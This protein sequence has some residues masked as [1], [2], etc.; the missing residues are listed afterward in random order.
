MHVS[1]LGRLP[2]RYESIESEKVKHP[3]HRYAD[4]LWDDGNRC[5]TCEGP[6]TEDIRKY[7]DQDFDVGC[8]D[9]LVGRCG[10]H[11]HFFVALYDALKFERHINENQRPGPN[12]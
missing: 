7:A 2:I 10:D 12:P 11:M 5:F 1:R 8:S 3:Q 4:A 6:E 9:D